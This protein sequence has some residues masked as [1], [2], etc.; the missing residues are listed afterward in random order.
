[1]LPMAGTSCVVFG[2]GEIDRTL[3]E[4]IDA[5][6]RLTICVNRASETHGIHWQD[7]SL[8]IDADVWHDAAPLG[9]AV[10]D[11]STPGPGEGIALP[12]YRKRLTRFLNPG[13]LYHFPNTAVVA[14]LW[15]MSVGCSMVAMIGCGCEDD[16]RRASQL[17]SMRKARDTMLDTYSDARLIHTYLDWKAW[18]TEAAG[19]T[20]LYG[21]A[22]ERLREFYK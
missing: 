9:L 11:S 13:H 20:R 19:L 3:A 16:G 12:M 4:T 14:A 10:Y 6:H 22:A 1:M 2:C 18:R 17:L 7:V 8:W 15:A 5:D 21:D